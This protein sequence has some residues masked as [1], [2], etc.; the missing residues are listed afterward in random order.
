MQKKLKVLLT[1]LAKASIKFV[2]RFGI[3]NVVFKF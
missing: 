3:K 1:L 2:I